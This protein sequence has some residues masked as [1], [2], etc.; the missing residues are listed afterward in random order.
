MVSG[1]AADMAAAMAATNASYESSLPSLKNPASGTTMTMAEPTSDRS[2]F[3]L[4]IDLLKNILILVHKDASSRAA[5]RLTCRLFFDIY[6]YETN[7]LN[8]LLKKATYAGDVPFMLKFKGLGGTAGI[9]CLY[10]VVLTGEIEAVCLAKSWGEH[11]GAC[12]AMAKAAENGR[13]DIMEKF[14]GWFKDGSLFNRWGDKL[15]ESVLIKASEFGQLDAVRLV[16]SWSKINPE[17]EIPLN[18]L[19]CALEQAA[20]RGHLGAMRLLLSWIK[21]KSEEERT[22]RTLGRALLEAASDNHLDAMQLVITCSITDFK[23]NIPVD[24]LNVA[25][26]YSALG[27]HLEAMI[28][29]ELCGA[30]DFNE[31]IYSAARCGRFKAVLLAKRMADEQGL[32]AN[33]EKILTSAAES[34]KLKIM[35]W[36][37]ELGGI[38]RGADVFND[39]LEDAAIGGHIEAME[40]AKEM[41]ASRF[42]NVYYSVQ[43]GYD[44]GEHIIDLLW[45]WKEEA[46]KA[47]E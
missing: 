5:I 44:V 35:R 4:T 46:E 42:E 11:Q 25:L 36:A 39:V 15:Y 13:L 14:Y 32:I 3:S 22:D 33:Y 7:E 26:V 2:M 6:P 38:E 28:L 47:E 31:A 19:F 45:M 8:H 9:V 43:W 30:N 21:M 34:G 10:T 23:E 37:I 20:S 40:F 41:G 12:S 1:M 27:G 16:S 24:D 17:R 29:L 18:K